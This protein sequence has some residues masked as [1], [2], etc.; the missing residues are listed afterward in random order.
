MFVF[1]L[2]W[3]VGASTETEGR[4]KFSAFLRKL[5]SGEVDKSEDRTDVDLGPG[6]TITEPTF[7][8]E[9]G[10]PKEGSCYDFMWDT[11]KL[12][13]RAWMDTVEVRPVDEALAYNSI[14]VQ[15]VDT[16]RYSHLLRTLVLHNFHA[17]YSGPTGTGKTVYV[18]QVLEGLDK[19]EWSSIQTAFSAQTNANMIQVGLN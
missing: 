7:K 18:K 11:T 6:L 2:I 13:W 10:L 3:S 14:V 5:L 4:A 8:R 15:T 9:A 16:V 19:A 12:S 17:L 1:A